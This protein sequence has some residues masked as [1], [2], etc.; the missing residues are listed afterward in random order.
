MNNNTDSDQY[1]F[2]VPTGLEEDSNRY[3]EYMVVSVTDTEGIEM[4]LVERVGSWEVDLSEYAT[5]KE[6]QDLST[7]VNTKVDNVVGSRLMTN[8][9][10]SKLASLANIQTTDEHL[11]INSGKLSL[12]NIPIGKVVNLENILNLIF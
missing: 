9:E 1:I 3:D 6:V 4:R 2:M 12:K 7:I 10:G 5:K 8:E 11:E